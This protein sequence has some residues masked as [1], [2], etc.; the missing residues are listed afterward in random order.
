VAGLIKVKDQISGKVVCT[1]TGNGLKDPDNAIKF[2]NTAVKKTSS[3]INEIL[4]V[5]DI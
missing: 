4:H 5:I 2:A 3:D 1:L